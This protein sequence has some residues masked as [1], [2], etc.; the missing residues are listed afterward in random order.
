MAGWEC[1]D[2]TIAKL[3]LL[4]GTL[5]GMLA[6]MLGAFGAHALKSVLPEPMLAVYH[7]AVNYQFYHA[8]ALVLCG[9]LALVRPEGHWGGPVGA[10]AFGSLLFCGSLYLLVLTGVKQ[11]GMVTPLGG[12]SFIVGWAWLA[13]QTTRL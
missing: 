2:V 10:F 8:L 3:A 11:W 7:T 6:V 12:I 13:W 1:A 9:V 5:S 4:W